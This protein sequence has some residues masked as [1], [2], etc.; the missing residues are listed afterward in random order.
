MKDDLLSIN[1]T[2]ADRTYPMRIKRSEEER[3]RKAAKIINKRILLYQ[4]RYEG[5]DIQDFL[6]MSSLQFVIQVL[7]LMDKNDKEPLLN[8]IQKI[9]EQITDY[10][11]EK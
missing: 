1:I 3:I 9:N 6:A 5:K 10:L 7:E 4:E 2:I 8:S 11:N